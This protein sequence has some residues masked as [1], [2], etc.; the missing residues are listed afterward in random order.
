LKEF[1]TEIDRIEHDWSRARSEER[2]ADLKEEIKTPEQLAADQAAVDQK[3]ATRQQSR[4]DGLIERRGERETAADRDRL[5]RET[6]IERLRTEL[7]QARDKAL[8][9]AAEWHDQQASKN[10]H[11]GWWIAS[12][13][14]QDTI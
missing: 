4:Q 14:H 6:E 5:D 9:E 3:T 7:S 11:R 2:R 12:R 13:D 8:E 10:S 1:Y